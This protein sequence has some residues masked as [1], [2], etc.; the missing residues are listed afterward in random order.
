MRYMTSSHDH[1]INRSRFLS[2]DGAW[3]VCQPR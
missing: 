2:W 3:D 1:V